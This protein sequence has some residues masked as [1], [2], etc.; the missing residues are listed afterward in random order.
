MS[1]FHTSDEHFPGVVDGVSGARA[2]HRRMA[3]RP[4][5]EP[6]AQLAS[7][8]I[9]DIAIDSLARQ[10][11]IAPRRM[12]G[13]VEARLDARL[14][15]RP[16]RARRVQLS[17]G[18]RRRRAGHARAAASRTL[19]FAGEAADAEGRTGT[20][21]G[22]IATGRRAAGEVQRSLTTRSVER[23]ARRI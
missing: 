1:F 3:R 8:E 19:F 6:L 11:G 15:A 21:H 4:G 23:A 12:R 17:D 14:G 7:E 5:R 13:M 20:V 2:D 18:R 10:F 22:A 16:V 9:E